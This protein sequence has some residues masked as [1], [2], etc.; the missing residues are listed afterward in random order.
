MIGSKQIKFIGIIGTFTII[1]I[2]Y[3]LH[4]KTYYA[5]LNQE[6]I[7]PVHH[8]T[9]LEASETENVKKV[10]EN[11]KIASIEKPLNLVKNEAKKSPMRSD[12]DKEVS[13][14]SLLNAFKYIRF[15]KS[16]KIEQASYTFLAKLAP[17]LKDSDKYYLE[18]EGY[19]HTDKKRSISQKRSEAYALS[20]KDALSTLSASIKMQTVGYSDQYPLYDDTK[21]R[22][23][24]RVELKLRR[25]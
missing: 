15:D 23:N 13:I 11:L 17:L 8:D 6:S 12:S 24:S 1:S 20:I 3:V 16:G 2:S 22:R 14:A 5:A 25:R 10:G 4:A 7:A 19:S 18:I 9:L 21:D